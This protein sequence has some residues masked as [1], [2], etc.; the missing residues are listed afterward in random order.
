MQRR[1]SEEKVQ[2]PWTEIVLYYIVQDAVFQRQDG[3]LF[4]SRR[5]V[6]TDRCRSLFEIGWRRRL[7]ITGGVPLEGPMKP[8]ERVC[9]PLEGV[10]Q[11]SKSGSMPINMNGRVGIQIP[12]RRWGITGDAERD[13]VTPPGH[14]SRLS[15]ILDSYRRTKLIQDQSMRR[16]LDCCGWVYGTYA[17]V[18]RPVQTSLGGAVSC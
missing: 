13:S 15:L 7:V 10:Q 6:S 11:L 2:R 5:F 17:V 9:A 1:A 3:S 12:V 4:R 16:T 8:V 18:Y 14:Y